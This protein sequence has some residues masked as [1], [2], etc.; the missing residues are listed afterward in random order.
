MEDVIIMEKKYR[1]QSISDEQ[2]SELAEYCNANN[3]RIDGDEEYYYLLSPSE[4]LVNGEIIDNSEEYNRER[5]SRLKEVERVRL[6]DEL[7]STDYKVLK[8]YECALA[9]KELPYNVDE[10]HKERQELRDRIN[11]LIK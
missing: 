4:Q 3:M 10:L 9:G 5:D 8:C 7:S 2:Y 11:L 1:I 6:I